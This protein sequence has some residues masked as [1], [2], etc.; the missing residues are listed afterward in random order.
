MC[1]LAKHKGRTTGH[2]DHETTEGF[3]ADP[4]AGKVDSYN[5]V[6][7][8]RFQ[9]PKGEATSEAIWASR[10]LTY[11]TKGARAGVMNPVLQKKLDQQRRTGSE[12]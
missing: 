12:G 7:S 5:I 9:I 1:A 2:A 3:S 6:Y 10:L 8:W 4:P 11:D